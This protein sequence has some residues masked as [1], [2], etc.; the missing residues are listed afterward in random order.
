MMLQIGGVVIRMWLI[1]GLLI[2]SG[3]S[4]GDRDS[5]VALG[6][7]QPVLV[8]GCEEGHVA[9]YLVVPQAQET[10]SGLVE[11]GSIDE[12]AVR[13]QLDSTPPCVDVAP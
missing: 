7:E 3:C 6:D 10:E 13:I 11:S 8:F 5:T 2:A 1:S 4:H 12:N 9:A